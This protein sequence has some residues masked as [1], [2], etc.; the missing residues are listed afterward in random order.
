MSIKIK[1]IVFL[2]AVGLVMSLCIGGY[3]YYDARGQIFK[4]ALKQAE[5]VSSFAI[6]SRNYAVR[7]MRPLAVKIAGEGSF[8]PELMGGFFIAK[9]IS[10]LFAKSQPGYSF[11]QA[12]LNPV[13]RQNKA[14]KQ[15]REIINYFSNNTGEKK[16][17]GVIDKQG[18]QFFYVAQPVRAG[19]KCLKCHGPRENAPQGRVNRYPDGGGYDYPLNSVVATFITYIPI[20]T[21]LQNVKYRA[22]KVSGIGFIFVLLLIVAIWFYLE[23]QIISPILKLTAMTDRMSRGK[24]LGVTI[25]SKQEDEIGQLYQS[26]NRMSVSVVR[27]LK[28]LKR[29]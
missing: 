9:A 26:F 11:K 12:A 5:V 17:S 21:A 3:S 18:E 6:A 14:D 13:N 29:K 24:G 7:T 25:K 4:D 23:A 1:V 19:K 16:K 20:E 2:A 28:M 27:L 10:D 22:L 15:E 8:H